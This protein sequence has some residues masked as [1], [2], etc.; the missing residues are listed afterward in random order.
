[1]VFYKSFHRKRNGQGG[2]PAGLI[3]LIAFFIVLYVL[4]IPPEERQKILGDS[5][6][7]GKSKISSDSNDTLL[8]EHP[9]SISSISK[10]EYEHSLP[11]L[12]VYT[13]SEGAL[14]YEVSDVFIERSLFRN[15]EYP[16]TINLENKDTFAN[17][18]LSFAATE[19]S[20]KLIVSVNDFEVYVNEP[21][22]P[23]TN[24][25]IGKDYLVTGKNTIKL[26]VQD[27]RW[28]FWRRNYFTLSN[29]R[30]TADIIDTS[31]NTGIVSFYTTSAEMANIESTTLKFYPKCNSTKT[32][33]LEV[34]INGINIFS[35]LPDC[36]N[37]VQK[38]EVSPK[39]ILKGE[40]KIRFYSENGRYLIDQISLTNK[41]SDALRHIYYFTI[42]DSEY[43]NIR[44]NVLNSQ[45]V[46][47]F[48]DDVTLKE[49]DIIVNNQKIRVKTR[50]INYNKTIND[51]LKKGTNAVELVPIDTWNVVDLEVSLK[52]K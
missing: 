23:N 32:S 19:H 11:S 7:D 10:D 6:Y 50:D 22:N 31:K 40:N 47:N 46:M 28:V 33:P 34:D 4:F 16:I 51:Y 25:M 5:D 18:M 37:L 35:G 44:N 30:L 39:N 17:V 36:N 12:Q 41:L 27:P 52:S 1:M 26:S 45:I 38:I 2:A 49:G 42:K 14:L 21:K 13:K 9:G 43:S 15:D 20:G 24:I 3:I 29:I 48:I 8:I